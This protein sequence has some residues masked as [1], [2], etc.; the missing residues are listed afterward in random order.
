[1]RA[2]FWLCLWLVVSVSRVAGVPSMPSHD[3]IPSGRLDIAD[4]AARL[5]FEYQGD[6]ARP[7]TIE[8]PWATGARRVARGL[9]TNEERFVVSIATD[10]AGPMAGDLVLRRLWDTGQGAAR[11][12]VTVEGREMGVWEI[13]DLSTERRWIETFFV[14]P[15]AKWMG[16]AER[17]PPRVSVRVRSSLELPSYEYAFFISSDWQ[18]L[19]EER[20]GSLVA[21]PGDSEA[22][23]DTFVQG[24]VA[25]GRRDL[26]VAAERFGTLAAHPT[27][28]RAARRW[29][30]RVVAR[31]AIDRMAASVAVTPIDDGRAV[32][33]FAGANGFWEEAAEAWGLRMR[34]RPTD[35]EATFRYA[36]ALAYC[37]Q[38]V[39]LWAPLMERAGN[40]WSRGAAVNEVD[41]L[42]ALQTQAYPKDPTAEPRLCN[43]LSLEDVEALTRD[44][45]ICEQIVYGASRG[46]YRLRSTFR[47]DGPDDPDWVMHLGWIFGPPDTAIPE[48]GSFDYALCFAGYNSSHT[49]GVD[50]GIAG[51]AA[52]QIGPRR[53]WEVFLHEWNHQFDWIA[54]YGEQLPGY[55]VTH[56][57]DGC[58]KQPI[59]SMGV[60]HLASMAY[61]VTPAEYRRHEGADPE[62]AGSHL[63]RWTLGGLTAP[64]V[65]L[66]IPLEEALVVAG[67]ADAAQLARW[68][69][70]WQQ[71]QAGAGRAPVESPIVQVPAPQPIPRR[72][73]EDFLQDRWEAT[74]ILDRLGP[75]SL[76]ALA[77]NDS[78]STSR[79][80]ESES[81][82]IDLTAAFSDLPPKV[83]VAAET[84]VHSDRSREVRL[85]VGANDRAALWVN[86]ER[87]LRGS[88]V[89][90]AKWKDASRTD[91]IAASTHLETGW[92]R[93]VVVAER[94]GGG[95]G[96]SVRISDFEGRPI[97][98]LEARPARPDVPGALP[99]R[100]V[101]GP[102]YDWEAVRDDYRSL[103]P[104][105]SV[106]DL[107]T[108]T[109]LPLELDT[110][111][112]FIRG[113]SA[114]PG[115]RLIEGPDPEDQALNNYLNWDL[116]AVAALRYWR[117]GKLADLLFVRPEYFEEYLTLAAP[118]GA[119][120]QRVLGVLEIEDPTYASTP[121]HTGRRHVLVVS[122][123][124]PERYPL[125]EQDLLK[126]RE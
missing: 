47:V 62:R 4:P 18:W 77:A 9:M 108:L 80:F 34:R 125:D 19:G 93:L 96:F 99:A 59:P 89:A 52:S 54:I 26:V 46:S 17:T 37:R 82:F 36:E 50:C 71:E 119:L 2:F 1:M 75:R 39:T 122:A 16:E 24:L 63:R 3:W 106:T 70:E 12:E 49:G 48:R 102:S 32:A 68:R 42:V 79:V 100:P 126:L 85:W 28:G 101:V 20:A 45:R 124:L 115:A 35:P 44:W 33:L 117:E 83:L 116:E 107:R 97:T 114:F 91:M 103:L 5:R 109:G 40:L 53:G 10:R 88:Y 25:A 123:H 55:P 65:P 84:W 29:L 21:P 104:R 6:S 66:N 61:Y 23:E 76:E 15:L 92:N 14:V 112:F 120:R 81:D 57:S 27:L 41:V 31:R 58:G 113:V 98:D 69:E 78:E 72:S 110:H 51:S 43:A 56:D 22:P 8:L 94:L 87:R 38:P 95:F 118:D 60:G 67:F 64:T 121:G 13:P 7:A 90:T 73:F 111:R 105:L 30:R 86:G 74:S 11:L